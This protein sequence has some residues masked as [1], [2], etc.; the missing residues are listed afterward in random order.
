MGGATR[1]LAVLAG[2]LLLAGCGSP[3]YA[4]TNIQNA[5]PAQ[6]G[7]AGTSGPGAAR[8]AALLHMRAIAFSPKTVTVHVGQTV[9]WVN[10]DPVVHNVTAL[11]GHT[12]VS[13]SIGRHGR[14]TYK[15]RAAETIRYYCTIHASSMVATLVVTP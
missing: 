1:V 13:P 10:D 11:D 14:F 8:P 7:L 6:S 9:E 4:P 12:I 5:R 15:A 3:G 2:V